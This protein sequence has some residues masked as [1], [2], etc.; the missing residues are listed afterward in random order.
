MAEWLKT[1]KGKYLCEINMIKENQ[2][3]KIT[4]TYP[5]KLFDLCLVHKYQIL[6]NPVAVN[7]RKV[8]QT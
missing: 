2:E 8:V 5:V 3:Q 6:I 7:I 1:F 4:R